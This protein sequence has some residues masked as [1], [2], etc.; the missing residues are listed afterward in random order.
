MIDAAQP[1]LTLGHFAPLVGQR[2]VL[3]TE[4]GEPVPATLAE[5][6]ALP[7]PGSAGRQGFALLFDLALN[8]VLPQGIYPIAHPAFEALTMFLVPVARTPGG[9]RCEAVFN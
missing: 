9:V 8:E 7:S 5:A 1:L 6:T 3:T 4:G 2:F